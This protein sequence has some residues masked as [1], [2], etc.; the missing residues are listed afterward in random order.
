MPNRY[1]NGGIAMLY[2]RPLQ[3]INY[4]IHVRNEGAFGLLN[5]IEENGLLKGRT[6]DRLKSVI[7][8]AGIETRE[9]LRDIAEAV[10]PVLADS[11]YFSGLELFV[12]KELVLRRNHDVDPPVDIAISFETAE[13]F[14]Y[15][16]LV[17]AMA[18]AAMRLLEEHPL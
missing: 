18:S 9:Y 5:A 15:E 6:Q 7:D 3:S 12:G 13:Q 14:T 17:E 2:G 4:L 11:R 10:N 1:V 8:E 16:K